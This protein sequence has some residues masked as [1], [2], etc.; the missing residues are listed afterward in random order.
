MVYGGQQGGSA[1]LVQAGPQGGPAYCCQRGLSLSGDHCLLSV[2]NVGVSG[3]AAHVQ[4]RQFKRP[5]SPHHMSKAV[6]DT[7][8][9]F[10]CLVSR[11]GL[12]A[13]SLSSHLNL[14]WEYLLLVVAILSGDWNPM[15]ILRQA[16]AF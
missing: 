16:E 7:Y 3:N 5:V 6:S 15:D 12:A 13:P 11:R 14:F 8:Q 10:R 9:E 1:K 2:M 4:A